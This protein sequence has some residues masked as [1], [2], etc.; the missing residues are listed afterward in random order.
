MD[1]LSLMRTVKSVSYAGDT[2]TSKCAHQVIYIR[3]GDHLVRDP[4][5]R[6]SSEPR[7]KY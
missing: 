2:V 5:S 6:Q 4:A 7:K 3:H 1:Y